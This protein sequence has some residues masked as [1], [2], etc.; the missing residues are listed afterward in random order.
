MKKSLL[1]PNQEK[2][3]VNVSF[4]SCFATLIS[5]YSGIKK[6]SKKRQVPKAMENYETLTTDSLCFNRKYMIGSK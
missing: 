4:Y 3:N 6:P 1:K 5:Y 2:K